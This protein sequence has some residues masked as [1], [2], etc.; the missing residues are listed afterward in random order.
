MWSFIYVYTVKELQVVYL[1]KALGLV[2]GKWN[3]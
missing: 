1:T 3:I 2:Y